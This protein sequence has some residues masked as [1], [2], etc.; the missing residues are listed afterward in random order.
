MGAISAA[1]GARDD[2]RCEA[3]S[4]GD[5]EQ[6]IT[7]GAYIYEAIFPPDPRQRLAR[8]RIG[9]RVGGVCAHG[10]VRSLNMD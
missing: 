9:S 5:S 10:G 6:E 1:V 3:Q 8:A 2:A 7:A 4:G